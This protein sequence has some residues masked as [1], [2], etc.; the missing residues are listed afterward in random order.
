MP[1]TPADLLDT[2]ETVSASPALAAQLISD[3]YALALPYIAPDR[4]PTC[5][6]VACLDFGRGR[7]VC[8]LCGERRA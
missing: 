6:A 8:A 4:C 2:A 7:R 5:A 1:G 3:A